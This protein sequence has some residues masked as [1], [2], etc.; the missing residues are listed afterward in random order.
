[1]QTASLSWIKEKAELGS[2]HLNRYYTEGKD[3]LTS[4]DGIKFA[5]CNQWGDNFSNFIQQVE[6]LGWKVSEE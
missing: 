2:D 6:K 5:V 3:L 4:A 1:M